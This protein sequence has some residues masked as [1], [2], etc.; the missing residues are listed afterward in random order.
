MITASKDVSLVQETFSYDDI[1]SMSS[2]QVQV[3]L[4]SLLDKV[5][6]SKATHIT[7]S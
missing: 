5:N 7:F 1:A 6:Y 4:N 2:M 3:F